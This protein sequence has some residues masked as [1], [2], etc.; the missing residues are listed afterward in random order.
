MYTAIDADGMG[1]AAPI[2]TYLMVICTESGGRA[3]LVDPAP[4]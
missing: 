4:A 2:L 1:R 3:A